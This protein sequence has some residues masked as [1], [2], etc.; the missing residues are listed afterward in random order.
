MPAINHVRNFLFE[1]ALMHVGE[2]FGFLPKGMGRDMLIMSALAATPSRVYALLYRGG[3]HV[4]GAIVS[5]FHSP[6]VKSGSKP[7]FTSRLAR[8]GKM[9][10]SA[11]VSPKPGSVRNYGVRRIGGGPPL[12]VS[13]GSLGLGLMILAPV[14]QYLHQRET[15]SLEYHR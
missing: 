12:G 6:A 7:Q 13:A 2:K 1:K 14:G 11:E 3:L 9:G 15:S 4:T 5:R 10:W 8:P